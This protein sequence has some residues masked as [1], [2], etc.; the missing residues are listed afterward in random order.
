MGNILDT[1]EFERWNSAS[2]DRIMALL[3]F[4]FD[5]FVFNF[6]K[7]DKSE[8]IPISKDFFNEIEEHLI[9]IIMRFL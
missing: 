3:I 4:R 8:A 5:V 1:S 6:E 9:V 7:N 2:V